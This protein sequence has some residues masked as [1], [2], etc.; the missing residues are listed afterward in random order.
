[1]KCFLL[2]A[3]AGALLHGIFPA[4]AQSPS[5]TAEGSETGR[6]S[7]SVTYGTNNLLSR[8]ADDRAM[9]F[10]FPDYY[11]PTE[12]INPANIMSGVSPSGGPLVSSY[13]RSPKYAE[14]DGDGKLILAELK[15]G[16]YRL[17][18]ISK[19]TLA[20]PHL[21][22]AAKEILQKYL[23]DD[24]ADLLSQRKLDFVDIDISSGRTTQKAFHFD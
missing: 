1:M 23:T 2:F 16:N 9:V 7:I 17:I 15:P 20:G 19:H 8:G 11:L 18:V 21:R 3:L 24:W 14:T 22:A 6:L 4:H 13:L 5:P 10:L 12:K